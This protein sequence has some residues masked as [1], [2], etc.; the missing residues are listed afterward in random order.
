MRG[1]EH[2][3]DGQR[4]TRIC[5]LVDHC[6]PT[7]PGVG[8][9]R[10]LDR[11]TFKEDFSCGGRDSAGQDFDQRRFSGALSPEMACTSPRRRSKSMPFSAAAPRYS[12]TVVFISRSRLSGWAGA[13]M[14]STPPKC[15]RRPPRRLSHTKKLA[16]NRHATRDPVRSPGYEGWRQCDR[17]Y[18]GVAHPRCRL[19]VDSGRHISV[20]TIGAAN[21]A[22]LQRYF[23]HE[24]DKKPCWTSTSY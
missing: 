4:G 14:T 20:G 10:D 13:V 22:G 24:N 19:H 5:L 3:R 6:D 11:L 16:A 12:L 1:R 2:D 18:R 23:L 9:T 15:T 7:S 21:D 8:R 17:L